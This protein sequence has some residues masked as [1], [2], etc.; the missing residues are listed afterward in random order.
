MRLPDIFKHRLARFADAVGAKLRRPDGSIL[1][2]PYL[3]AFP[4]FSPCVLPSL[5]AGATV[6]QS[7]TTAT[8]TAA[9]HGIV[10]NNGRDGYKVYFPGS[11]SIPAGWYSGFAYVDANTITFQ[12][13]AATVASESVNGGAAY[14]LQT[15]IASDTIP[16]GVVGAQGSVTAVVSRSA[17]ASG[18]SKLIST[19]FGTTLLASHSVSTTPSATAQ[20]LTTSNVG[21]EARQIALPLNDGVQTAAAPR[22][23]TVDTSASFTY[24]VTGTVLS[25]GSCLIIDALSYEVIQL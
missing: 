5:V 6:S 10:G 2:L 15:T 17:D 24:S 7:G 9:G 14:L 20:R 23:G 3:S 11:T 16:G 4:G 22:Y 8:V 12:R 19:L 25:A 1:S 18:T 13:V 21:S